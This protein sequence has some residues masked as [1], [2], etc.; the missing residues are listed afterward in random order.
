MSSS[1]A[2]SLR[3]LVP[4]DAVDAREA[5]GDAG[6]VAGRLL[7]RVEGDFET[8]S[9]FTSRTGPKAATVLLRTHLSSC[10]SSSSVK[11]KYALP[12]GDDLV[13]LPDAESVVGVERRSLA[14]ATLRIHQD[15]IDDVGVALPF[16]PQSLGPARHI[17]RCPAA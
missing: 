4:A 11:P 2:A 16:E 5:Q 9:F 14:V 6:F 13:A 12:I 8:S 17:G 7:R 10:F 15:G 3:R 1:V